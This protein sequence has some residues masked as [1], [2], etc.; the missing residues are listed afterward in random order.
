MTEKLDRIES[1]GLEFHKKVQAGYDYISKIESDRF[2]CIDATKSID[3]I[4][5]EI[6]KVLNEKIPQFLN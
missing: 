5:N 3:E 6:I 4:F 1:E 2:Y